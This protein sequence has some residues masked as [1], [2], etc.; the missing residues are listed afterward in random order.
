[1][2][3]FKSFSF[4]QTCANVLRFEQK[5]S[6]LSPR[7]KHRTDGLVPLLLGSNRHGSAVPL[8]SQRRTA[9]PSIGNA[10]PLL[11]SRASTGDNPPAVDTMAIP[12]PNA[13][14]VHKI[15]VCRSQM[16]L[17]VAPVGWEIGWFIP[18][19]YAMIGIPAL[20]P[21]C[22]NSEPERTAH[23]DEFFVQRSYSIASPPTERG[24]IE[25]YITLVRDGTLS[26]RLFALSVGDKL[27]L[28]KNFSGMFTFLRVSKD[29]NVVFVATG[30]GLS[31]CMSLIRSHFDSAD[32]RR[33]A[34]IHGA[35]HSCE[36]GYRAELES[37]AQKSDRF[38]YI[39]LISR[40]Q[41]ETPAW[42]GHTGYVQDVWKSGAIAE[43]WGFKPSPENTHVF[44]SGNPAMCDA[45][46]T[47]L[48]EQGYREQT[49]RESGELHLERFW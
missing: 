47:I 24:H 1:M 8:R 5:S 37:L 35:R 7:K 15:E 11:D 12:E 14:V 22:A 43:A 31:P 49:F 4:S 23:S 28:S 27:W 3:G 16:I 6:Y 32:S 19:Q 9:A 34:L 17:R 36:L 21:R 30:T 25:F 45:M 33:F 39:N 38:T 44:V 29:A 13:I 46:T 26:P 2:L 10:A 40:P 48:K 18:G 20:A 41:E 42:K